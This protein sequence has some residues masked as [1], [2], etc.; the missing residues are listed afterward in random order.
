MLEDFWQAVRELERFW[1]Y[2]VAAA[3][4]PLFAK[5]VE[6]TPPWPS[7]IAILTSI[8][9]LLAIVVA[10]QIYRGTSRRKATSV[11]VRATI[12][13]FL[14]SIAYLGM[15][16]ELTFRQPSGTIEIKGLVCS[17]VGRVTFPE[18]CPWLGPAELKTA[19]WT[20][21]I[22]WTS[23][24]ITIARILIVVSWLCSFLLLSLVLA[25]FIIYQR[26]AKPP[27]AK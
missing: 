15:I 25:T 3:A 11:I 17:E 14:L 6:L 1:A 10:Y 27:A 16:S 13:L 19:E 12:L 2:I 5:F 26:S 20:P 7:S 9:N 21:E 18:K 22:L 4:L 24:S 8:V 23:W